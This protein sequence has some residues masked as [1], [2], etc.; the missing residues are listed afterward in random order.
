MPTNMFYASIS[1]EILRIGRI[2]S[3]V[4]SFLSC[5][6]PVISRALKQGANV[7]NLEKSLKK[8][9]GRHDILKSFGENA[10]LFANNL[11]S[12]EKF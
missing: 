12:L 6:E 8:I 7:K 9:Y 11:V 5:V 4:D 10:Q 2:C 1:A 3:K